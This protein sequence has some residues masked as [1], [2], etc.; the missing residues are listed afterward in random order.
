MNINLDAFYSSASIAE[1]QQVIGEEMHY[2]FGFFRGH[3]D[4][5]TG[6]RRAVQNLYPHI[7]C[8]ARVLDIG[9]GWGGPAN[10]LI[11]ERGCTVKGLTIASAQVAYCH[12]LGLDVE[13]RDIERDVLPT[14]YDVA[15]LLEVLE[16]VRDK[17]TL[18]RRLRRCARRL[19]IAVNCLYEG[20]IH[21]DMF[22]QSVALC[23][24]QEL[25][26]ALQETGWAIMYT[27][28]RRFES[29]RSLSCWKNN[30]DHL[31]GTAEPPG[32]LGTL[33]AFVAHALHR[34]ITWALAN[35][36]V[37]VVADHR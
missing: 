1:W 10:L 14:G 23:T 4:L 8:G 25:C 15:L 36:L 32:Q 7:P 18:L 35:P 6:A 21:R 37:D 29:L 19:V 2:H 26:S 33:R 24:V 28:Q 27:R 31:Y 12:K 22:G 9:C 3:E 30:L 16:H 11:R 17:A 20:A 13:R 5:Q 34:P